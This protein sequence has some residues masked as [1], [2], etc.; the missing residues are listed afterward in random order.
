MYRS[1][2]AAVVV[3]HLGFSPGFCAPALR[4]QCNHAACKQEKIVRRSRWRRGERDESRGVNC[5]GALQNH[6]GD[7]RRAAEV[8]GKHDTATYGEVAKGLAQRDTDR[9]PDRPISAITIIETALRSVDT[10]LIASGFLAGVTDI[11]NYKCR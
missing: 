8:L 9:S 10:P 1:R 2:A 5:R 6:R 7:G 3:A 11:G 4:S